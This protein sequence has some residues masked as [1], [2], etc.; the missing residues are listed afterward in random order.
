MKDIPFYQ[1]PTHRPPSK[2][3]R[4]PMPGSSDS[5]E[6]TDIN[7]EINVN[8]EENPPF[9]EGV[10]SEMYHRP[11]KSFFQ[12]P[13]GLEGLVNTDNLVQSVY[14]SRLISIWY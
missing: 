8:F 13:W 7:P 3:V 11:D 1:D 9:Q 10:V 12:D 4:T 6:S 2:P 14:Q 5:S